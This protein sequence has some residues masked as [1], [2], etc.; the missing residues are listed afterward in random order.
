MRRPP[1]LFCRIIWSHVMPDDT[2][3]PSPVQSSDTPAIAPIPVAIHPQPIN[4]QPSGLQPRKRAVV[5]VIVW[6][7]A[8]VIAAA[9]IASVTGLIWYTNS[10][11]PVSGDTQQLIPLTVIAGSTPSDI[12]TQLR[13]A[14]LIQS[15][16]AFDIYTRL[17]DTRGSLQAGSYRLSPSEST[18]EIVKHL[19]NGKVDQFSITFLPGATLADHRQVLIDAGYSASEVDTALAAS[20]DS[21]I[22]AGKPSEASL[23]GYIYGETYSFGTGA[24]AVDIL[25]YT[26]DQ[27]A[28]VVTDNNLV[29]SFKSQGLTLYQGITLASIIQREVS[30]SSGAT[31]PSS[32]QKQVSQVFHTRLSSGMPLGSDVTFIYAA[33]LLGIEPISTLDSP[34]NTRITVGL[35]PGPISSPGLTALI[36]TA[37]PAAGDYMYFVAGDDGKTYFGRTL[38]EHE[39]NVARYCTVECNKP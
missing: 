21:P 24:S 8:A 25:Q 18:P 2:Q 9:I 23:E 31:T 12:G 14:G 33:K 36:A 35:P 34:Y 16:T 38:A 32:D 29:D 19:T 20:Y 3:Q 27:F 37:S 4:G 5:K 17:S 13:D 1:P 15:V 6:A 39:S 11:K 22:F 10:L 30:S 28:S 26:F 7:I